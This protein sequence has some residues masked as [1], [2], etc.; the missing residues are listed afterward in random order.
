MI[1]STLCLLCL[2][3]LDEIDRHR[4]KI[5]D[6]PECDS[7]DDEVLRKHNFYLKVIRY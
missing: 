6:F 4:I 7:D 1:N 5:F 2:Q 3:I